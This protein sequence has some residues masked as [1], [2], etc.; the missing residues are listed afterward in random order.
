MFHID[1]SKHEINF[2]YIIY[3]KI[4]FT[5]ISSYLSRKRDCKSGN[6]RMAMAVAMGTESLMRMPLRK[7]LFPLGLIFFIL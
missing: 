7:F 1:Y 6:V 4:I 3:L 5:V 2:V